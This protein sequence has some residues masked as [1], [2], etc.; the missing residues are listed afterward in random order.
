[1]ADISVPHPWGKRL[2]T[3]SDSQSDK[4]TPQPQFLFGL[5][6]LCRLPLFWPIQ[7]LQDYRHGAQL[8][9]AINIKPNLNQ[10]CLCGLQLNQ[11]TPLKRPHERFYIRCFLICTLVCSDSHDASLSSLPSL[12]HWCEVWLLQHLVSYSVKRWNKHLEMKRFFFCFCFNNKRLTYNTDVKCCNHVCLSG[13]PRSEG[14]TTQQVMGDKWGAW[15]RLVLHHCHQ[16]G[17]SCEVE[18]EAETMKLLPEIENCSYT[19][20]HRCRHLVKE[21]RSCINILAIYAIYKMQTLNSWASVRKNQ[22]QV[23]VCSSVYDYIPYSH[24][25]TQM[26]QVSRDWLTS[27]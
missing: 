7:T 22:T 18:G 21:T 15:P 16:W 8:S 5:T 24:N 17:K 25:Q 13:E 1:M 12:K 26:S 11:T 10:S 23:P 9:L 2:R 4:T 27:V 19:G 20:T 3:M 14:V 6:V